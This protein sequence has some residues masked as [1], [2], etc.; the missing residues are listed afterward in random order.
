MVSIYIL[1]IYFSNA[2]ISRSSTIIIAYL[3]RYDKFTLEDALLTVQKNRPAAKPN[4]G[5]MGKLV[6]FEKMLIKE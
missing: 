2:G 4:E 5:F 1:S 3:M 6:E